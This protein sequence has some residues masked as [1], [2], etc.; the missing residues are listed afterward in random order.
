MTSFQVALGAK[1]ETVLAFASH[2]RKKT[3]ITPNVSPSFGSVAY[4]GS[5]TSLVARS[6]GHPTPTG[7][8][9]AAAARPENRQ[10]AMASARRRFIRP[11][12]RSPSRRLYGPRAP[13]ATRLRDDLACT[14]PPGPASH[15]RARAHRTLAR[16]ARPAARVRTRMAASV[17]HDEAAAP[18]AGG[19]AR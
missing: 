3:G 2:T 11:R 6:V 9:P 14:S 15:S 17:P 13:F 18:A 16:L 5:G 8:S 7:A 12:P 4:T 1:I 10:A 19:R